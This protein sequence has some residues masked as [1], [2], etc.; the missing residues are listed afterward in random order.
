MAIKLFDIENGKIKAGADCHNIETY[1][2]IIKEYPKDYNKIFAYFHYMSSLDDGDNPFANTPEVDKEELILKEVGGNFTTEE[3][4]VYKGLELTKK[5][6]ETSTYYAYLSIKMALEK[7]GRYLRTMTITDGRDGNIG[8]ILRTAEKYDSIC[9]SF[10]A[11]YKAFKE[12][13]STISR[14]NQATAYDQL[15]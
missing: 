1:K 3:E 13:N 9:R 5:L 15:L 14:G 6:Y 10:D 7:L 12:E 2:Q 8:D 4:L 11:R